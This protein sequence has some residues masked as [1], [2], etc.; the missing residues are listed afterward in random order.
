MRLTV[1]SSLPAIAAGLLLSA[2]ARPPAPSSAEA[3][4]VTVAKPLA[5]QIIEWDDYVGEFQPVQRVE[6]RPRVSGYVVAVH[7]EDGDLVKK[8]QRLFTIDP[9]PVQ[10]ALAQA[11][12]DAAGASARLDNARAE[13]ERIR[14]LAEKHL[15]SKEDLDA[16]EAAARTAEAALEAAKAAVQAQKL[17]LDFTEI[18]APIDGRVSYRRVDPG[19]SVKA[20]ETVLTTIVSVDPIYFEFQGSEA[21]YLKYKRADQAAPEA[22]T[23]RI[24]LQ[25]EAAPRWT[26]R[27]VFMDNAIDAGTIRG[28]ALVDNADGFLTP[29][30]FGHMQLQASPLHT[31]L[32]VPDTAVATRGADRILYVVDGENLVAAR[33]VELGPLHDG[34]RVIRSGVTADDRIV[35]DGQLRARPGQKVAARVTTIEARADERADGAESADDAESETARVGSAGG[36]P[37]GAPSAVDTSGAAR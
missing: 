34:L 17:N 24:R 31:A 8:G 22:R 27:L 3:P 10:A 16:R 18:S 9:R 5:E 35:V 7:F 21:L 30:M 36:G 12:A 32:L 4:E 14:G 2:C 15:A 29:G 1:S 26:G 28:R 20:D 6:V 11:E 23:V 19:N 33:T 37:R 13:L 25:D